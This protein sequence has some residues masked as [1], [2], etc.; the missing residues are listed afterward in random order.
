MSLL[1]T[2]CGAHTQCTQQLL[3]TLGG[4]VLCE[5]FKVSINLQAGMKNVELC[6]HF[7]LGMLC[8]LVSYWNCLRD[9]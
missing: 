6:Y 3:P 2:L 9:S 5:H 7:T 4:K 1:V 8:K